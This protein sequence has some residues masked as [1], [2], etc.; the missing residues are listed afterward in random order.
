[1]GRFMIPLAAAAGSLLLGS[2]ET[3][4]VPGSRFS[5]TNR[6]GQQLT[7][8]RGSGLA[9]WGGSFRFRRG[10]TLS[11]PGMYDH[12]LRCGPPATGEVHLKPGKRW[13]LRLAPDNRLV[14]EEAGR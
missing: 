4:G 1:M 9:G 3:D 11:G 8:Q 10:Q 14:L 13:R 6:T 7:C 5:V 12:F 2:C